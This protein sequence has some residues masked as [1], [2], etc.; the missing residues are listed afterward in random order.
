MR[1]SVD[2]VPTKDPAKQGNPFAFS[3][4][5][6]VHRWSD[7]P[8]A[9]R[10][11]DQVYSTYFNGKDSKQIERKHVKVILLDLYV[12]WL[13]HPD[14]KM[15]VSMRPSTYKAKGTRYNALRISSKT[16][17]VVKDLIAA[18]LIE[19]KRGSYNRQ[20]KSGWITRIWPTP[21]LVAL[22]KK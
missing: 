14:L 20:L 19:Q 15:A 7:F 9:D 18:G 21:L 6:D 10:F 16:I 12:A 13:E 4:P 8:E 2:D 1:K 11:V 5:L 3:R 22:F 17:K